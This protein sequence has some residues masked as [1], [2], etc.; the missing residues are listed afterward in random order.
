MPQSS[1]VK[2][3][4]SS[5]RRE[6][7]DS[8]GLDEF[9]TASDII[10]TIEQTDL[11]PGTDDGRQ[12]S[13][14]HRAGNELIWS[15]RNKLEDGNAT[16]VEDGI[17][18]LDL[19][20]MPDPNS[21]VQVLANHFS[22]LSQL[23]RLEKGLQLLK[24]AADRTA[25][26]DRWDKMRRLRDFG[27]AQGDKYN[28]TYSMNEIDAAIEA[29]RQIV[30]LLIDEDEDI[31][32][33][34]ARA[35]L[36]FALK[37]RL[38]HRDT[39]LPPC[40]QCSAQDMKDA[41]ETARLFMDAAQMC[42]ESDPLKVNYLNNHGNALFWKFRHDSSLL[43]DLDAAVKAL[44]DAL[45]Y[46][47]ETDPTRYVLL[48][49]LADAV[50][51]RFQGTTSENDLQK[52]DTTI[53]EIVEMDAVDNSVKAMYLNRLGYSFRMFF[54]KTRV[55]DHLDSSIRAY[56]ST[57]LLSP[58]GT[59]GQYIP[60]SGLGMAHFAR[61]EVVGLSRD[62]DKA[63]DTLQ[64]ASLAAE[65]DRQL[66]LE[67]LNILGCALRS[68]FELTRDPSSLQKAIERNRE[69]LDL[70]DPGKHPEDGDMGTQERAVTLSNLGACFQIKFEGDGLPETLREAINVQQQAVDLLPKTDSSRPVSLAGL[71][72][73]YRRLYD[74][75]GKV[76]DIDVA[77]QLGKEALTLPELDEL[78]PVEFPLMLTNLGLA[79]IRRYELLGSV[80]DL[81]ESVRY[82][83][84]A[85]EASRD[86]PTVHPLCCSNCSYCMIT[87]F[88]HSGAVEDINEA[89]A[90]SKKT[91]D[92][93][94]GNQRLLPVIQNNFCRST[95]EQLHLGL[96]TEA[97]LHEILAF[98]NEMVTSVP[99]GHTN[100]ALVLNCLAV[101]RTEVFEQTGSTDDLEL[102]VQSLEDAVSESMLSN[103]ITQAIHLRDLA[104]GLIT[105]FEWVGNQKDLDRSLEAA[106][107]SMEQMPKTHPQ[108]LL[109]LITY[110][111]ALMER[112]THTSSADDFNAAIA[113]LEQAGQC[114]PEKHPKKAT[115][116]NNLATALGL[117]SLQIGTTDDLNAA[118]QSAMSATKAFS[119]DF[120]DKAICLTN[121]GQILT[122]R[123]SRIGWDDDI[124]IA[125][126]AHAKALEVT[127]MSHWRYINILENLSSA[128]LM[129]FEKRHNTED[130][131]K[132]VEH[133][134]KTLELCPERR[135]DRARYLSSACSALLELAKFKGA[136]KIE[137]SPV[138]G[139][140]LDEAIENGMEAAQLTVGDESQSRPEILHNYASSLATRFK[141]D[142][143]PSDRKTAVDVFREILDSRRF[144]VRRRVAAAVSAAD[145]LYPDDVETASRML[146]QAIELLPRIIS[147]RLLRSDQQFILSQIPGLAADAA[148]L[149]M[150]THKRA[151]EAVRLLELG[152]GVIAGLY[153]NERS[154]TAELEEAHPELARR[155]RDAQG[156]LDRSEED[157]LLPDVKSFLQSQ[158][159]RRYDAVQ[160]FDHIVTE[161]REKPG[162][163]QFLLGP[164][165]NE[166]KG[167]AAEGPIVYLNV[168]RYG[169][170]ALVIT[171]ET[172]HPLPLERLK[173]DEVVVKAK[174]LC[175][176]RDNDSLVT[177]RVNNLALTKILQ[178]LWDHI[179]G[180]VLQY[181]DFTKTPESEDE[182]P[183]I[184]W[185]PVGL[186]SL[187][188][189]Q[190]A[191]RQ[192]GGM[193]V[194]DRVISSYATTARSLGL[195]RERISALNKQ[196]GAFQPQEACLVSMRTTPQRTDLP[197]AEAEIEAI[198]ELL[199]I[200]KTVLAQP[201][202]A[203]VLDSLKRSS[204]VH[205]ACHGEMHANPSLSRV[206][207][208]DWE[209]DLFSVHDMARTN[210]VRQARLAYLS[211]CHA[212]TSKDM[213]LLDEAMHMTGAC[214]LAGF[215]AVIG[216]LWK[217][218]DQYAPTVA[219]DVY[220]GMLDQD[221]LDVRRAARALHFA[222]RSLRSLS[223]GPRGKANPV[224][225]APYIYVGV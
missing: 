197:H 98:T 215:P 84:S 151:D 214:Q 97:N 125:V 55:I 44:D 132:A 16:G 82:S 35:D 37:A 14:L 83:K 69:L 17:K 27:L 29:H 86:Q 42:D 10:T 63:I 219:S 175:D 206:L 19:S 24:R 173:Y 182:W 167:L 150:R 76:E 20:D 93:A 48:S 141:R 118:V 62:L 126:E 205:F 72:E 6:D 147:R 74:M 163:D 57:L 61:Y 217:V 117:R 178:W 162:F 45:T 78:C 60:M 149:E 220:T 49:D 87:K 135:P 191:G 94:L 225:W 120:P 70:L 122:Q 28:T 119:G 99:P 184:W 77:V 133:S 52:L 171:E 177:R 92:L 189:I 12:A 88:Y 95:V 224:A 43:G 187:F 38:R 90:M 71:A 80:G 116:L 66:H 194:L 200:P 67:I 33:I 146:S 50:G 46:A 137:Q 91:L 181:L 75:L 129:R 110:G 5:E 136:S 108:Y 58:E 39:E 103:D 157:V 51:E 145:I 195:S 89:A 143:E 124:D 47:S 180:D 158:A 174:K 30:E 31:D 193:S 73:S 166:L 186:L 221:S 7:S 104:E 165:P 40:V 208:S 3:G 199:P 64:S 218:L 96:P 56:D 11:D 9:D 68:H 100:R 2:Q 23:E 210:L 185:I 4:S 148:A 107:R 207:F 79:L 32:R 142:K 65:G 128:L 179:V 8:D 134:R 190:A 111:R 211:A 54:D 222:L 106:K 202:K 114:L 155:F 172:I 223:E 113:A 209:D 127:A 36:G 140:I 1:T 112:A 105:R 81:E 18:D 13:I 216:T 204:I 153:I 213:Y 154:G 26:Q 138:A 25:P 169:C 183:R 152:R 196:D 15:Y 201:K 34:T 59:P 203:Q 130:L 21:N 188:P 109:H 168:S 101:V 115:C 198:A 212:G 176:I 53:Q 164:P 192:K 159:A 22:H 156:R 123:F 85:E 41:D 161:I 160:D 170:T 121:L 131:E 139:C 144:P 102:M